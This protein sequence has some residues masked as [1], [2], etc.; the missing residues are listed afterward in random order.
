[1]TTSAPNKH[2]QH[3]ILIA[4]PN[5]KYRD[6][7]ERKWANTLR[8]T[9]STQ[10]R[11]ATEVRD[12]TSTNLLGTKYTYIVKCNTK[13]ET[14][15]A[16]D[17]LHNIEGEPWAGLIISTKAPLNSIRKPL[18]DAERLGARVVKPT[19]GK[20]RAKRELEAMGLSKQ[21][22]AI[23][24]EYAGDDITSIIGLLDYLGTLS[25][26]EIRSLTLQEV[27]GRLP[28]TP[29][30][31]APWDI[32]DAIVARDIPK[33]MSIVNRAGGGAAF[34]LA[35]LKTKM[36][37]M[38]HVSAY[39]QGGGAASTEELSAF[40][41]SNAWLLQSTTRLARTA[42][43]ER[44]LAMSE[45][46]SQYLRRPAKSYALEDFQRLCITLCRT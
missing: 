22:V 21:H 42:G 20:N 30:T 5:D 6:Y 29:G 14:T 19:G 38:L 32:M 2:F 37:D 45:L 26:E 28:E 35:V 9:S 3:L 40:M 15:A 24:A 18:K 16:I 44:T 8:K 39:I 46:L 10:L 7:L 41:K 25:Q 1:M 27:Y 43:F 23:I 11:Q 34:P 36:E 31:R 33:T 12:T 4:D 17:T 13:E